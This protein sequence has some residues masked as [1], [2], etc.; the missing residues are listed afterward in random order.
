MSL[1][2]IASAKVL[3][4]MTCFALAPPA[5]AASPKLDV[6]FVPS[7]E[8][9]VEEMLQMGAVKAD[10][11]LYDLGSGD[12]RIV[13]TAARDIGAR[14]VGVDLDPERIAEARA[15][16]EKAGVSDKVRFIQGNVFDVDFSDAT[17]VTMYLFPEVN[18]K[19]RP[20]ILSE[21][22]PGTRVVSHAFDMAAWK[23]DAV[24]QEA[25]GTVYR[26]IVPAQ[27]AGSWQWQV[28]EREFQVEL[29]QDFQ[30][31]SGSASVDGQPAAITQASLEGDQ[32]EL[33]VAPGGGEPIRFSG[34]YQDGQLVGQVDGG[35]QVAVAQQQW[36]AQRAD[37]TRRG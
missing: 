19:L 5:L 7:R 37:E 23:P 10:D 29:E 35:G 11:L 22:R 34:R 18:L 2:R 33:T 20:R 32:L 28:G 17:V 12:G 4:V 16:A 25:S 3:L 9:V 21:L 36:V 8:D 15:N 24:S 13:I 26:W 6:P 30:E 1:L 27:V 14:G 31:I